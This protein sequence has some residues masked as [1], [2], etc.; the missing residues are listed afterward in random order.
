LKYIKTR[1]KKAQTEVTKVDPNPNKIHILNSSPTLFRIWVDPIDPNINLNLI[2]PT[3]IIIFGFG[4]AFMTPLVTTI[5]GDLHHQTSV[6]SKGSH[7]VKVAV[8]VNTYG[9][10]ATTGS[11]AF[12][13]GRPKQWRN[14]NIFFGRAE[15]ILEGPDKRFVCNIN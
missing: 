13:Y 15:F 11:G 9:V 2:D 12:Y 1:K 6:K 8:V 4:S 5:F 14:L 7:T 3:Q 10:R